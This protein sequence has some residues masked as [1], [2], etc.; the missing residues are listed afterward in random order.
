MHR[1]E[2]V[3]DAVH[4][5]RCAPHDLHEQIRLIAQQ[6]REQFGG[7]AEHLAAT[8]RLAQRID[9]AQRLHARGD[10]NLLMGVDPQCRDLR[11]RQFEV[12]HHVVDDR[13]Q[14]ALLMLD[15][16]R[17]RA[18]VQRVEEGV[19]QSRRVRIQRS[20]ALL[21]RSKCSHEFPGRVLTREPCV[22][23][24]GVDRLA[25]LGRRGNERRRRGR[26]NR[27]RRAVFAG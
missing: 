26:R 24:F 22:R 1:Q 27:S 23:G 16:R 11:W 13:E 4:F 8:H 20:Q 2:T 19:R 14:R 6:M 25:G 10:E 5:Y 15:A 17:V 9:R 21:A 3:F 12:E 18:F 7:R